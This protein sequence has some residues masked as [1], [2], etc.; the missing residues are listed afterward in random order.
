MDLETYVG[1]FHETNRDNV[2]AQIMKG[3]L[4][5][6]AFETE[7]GK[8]L[9][10]SAIDEISKKVM[11]ILGS[12]TEKSEEDQLKKIARLATEVHVAYNLLRSWAEILLAGEKHEE[13]MKK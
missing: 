2:V 4:I 9:F 5:K 13:A 1:T 6:K 11:A 8:A 12:C 7:A 3:R 10:N